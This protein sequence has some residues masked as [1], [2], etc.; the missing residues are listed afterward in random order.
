[1]AVNILV[2][3]ACKDEIPPGSMGRVYQKAKMITLFFFFFKI[4]QSNKDVRLLKHFSLHP[5][6]EGIL[7]RL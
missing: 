5:C 7:G 3:S 4:S 1:M 2:V 6:L